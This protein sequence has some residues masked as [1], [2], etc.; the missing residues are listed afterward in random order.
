M[1]INSREAD[2]R[3]P[4][5]LRKKYIS[6]WKLSISVRAVWKSM[7]LIHWRMTVGEGNDMG[8]FPHRKL[9]M[10]AHPQITER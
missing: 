7:E 4:L 5:P 6:I 8:A 10:E 2:M 1:L 9:C 3:Q